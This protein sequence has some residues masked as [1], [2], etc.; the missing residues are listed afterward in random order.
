[1]QHPGWAL[2]KQPSIGGTSHGQGKQTALDH[3]LERLEKR[4]RTV[5]P[6][7]LIARTVLLT[8]LIVWI[9][10]VI[11]IALARNDHQLSDDI[12]G[13]DGTVPQ[14]PGGLS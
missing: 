9:L 7:C 13:A 11:W 5:A 4:S 12:T 8:V 2:A 14:S 3:Y 1:M 10:A 6:G